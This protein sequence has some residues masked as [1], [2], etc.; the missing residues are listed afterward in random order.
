[1]KSKNFI[2]IVGLLICLFLINP[3]IVNAKKDATDSTVVTMESTEKEELGC[4]SI[5]GEDTAVGKYVHDLYNII[6]FAVPILLLALSIKDFGSAIISQNDDGVKKATS[7]FIKRLIIAVIILVV[8]TILN[9][10]LDILGFSE[11]EI[12]RL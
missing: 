7:S 3:N 12:C 6:K 2:I 11:S 5:F 1:M 10:M 9:F 8:P 4:N